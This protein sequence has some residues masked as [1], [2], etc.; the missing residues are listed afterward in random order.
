MSITL[1]VIKIKARLSWIWTLGLINRTTAFRWE[2][3][4]AVYED[5]SRQDLIASVDAESLKNDSG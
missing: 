1:M 2:V 4:E 5:K 3:D